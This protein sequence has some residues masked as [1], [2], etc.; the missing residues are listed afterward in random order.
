[1]HSASSGWRWTRSLSRLSSVSQFF[2]GLV[3]RHGAPHYSFFIIKDEH[4]EDENGMMYRNGFMYTSSFGRTLHSCCMFYRCCMTGGE[5]GVRWGR[6]NGHQSWRFN[7]VCR[8][9]S[10]MLTFS[11]WLGRPSTF[12]LTIVVRTSFRIFEDGD[13]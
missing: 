8:F 6:M 11:Q 4:R 9:N 3:T 1:M 2:V 12:S 7:V 5:I 10:E 13:E